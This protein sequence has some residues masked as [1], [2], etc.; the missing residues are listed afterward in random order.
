MNF[1]AFCFQLIQRNRK[2]HSQIKECTY[3]TKIKLD[4]SS[5]SVKCECSRV[6]YEFVIVYVSVCLPS[7]RWAR[8]DGF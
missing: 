8:C 3:E 6:F 5:S 1:G 4:L 2:K 7:F